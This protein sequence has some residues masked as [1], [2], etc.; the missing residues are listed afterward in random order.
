MALIKKLKV[1]KTN[2]WSFCQN[3]LQG[4]GKRKS[5]IIIL[6][7]YSQKG[8]CDHTENGQTFAR[9]ISPFFIKS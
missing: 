8:I 6:L 5:S 3:I 4:M 1:F 9:K 2:I 7:Y